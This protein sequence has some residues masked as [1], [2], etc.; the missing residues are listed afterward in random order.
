MPNFTDSKMGIRAVETEVFDRWEMVY[1]PPVI[2]NRCSMSM[3]SLSIN[4]RVFRSCYQLPKV[5]SKQT[6]EDAS[7]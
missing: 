3:L 5:P 1:N 7:D 2:E 4:W 6:R